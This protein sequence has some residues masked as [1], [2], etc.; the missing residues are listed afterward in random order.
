MKKSRLLSALLLCMALCHAGLRARAQGADFDPQPRLRTVLT[1]NVRN[2]FTDEGRMD[3]DDVAATIRHSGADLVALQELDSVTGRSGGRYVLGE[4]ATRTDMHPAYAP[5]IGYDGGKYG[6]GILSRQQPL[7]VRRVALPGR[8]EAR[9]ML[10][11]EFRDFVFA[12]THLSLTEQDRL[13]SLP[14][15]RAEAARYGKPF[16]L[17]GDFNDTPGS[18]FIQALDSIFSMQPSGTAPT[19]PATDPQEHIDYI[20]AYN[21]TGHALLWQKPS[22]PGH[23]KAS[24]HRPLLNRF[25]LRTPLERMFFSDPYLQ[26]P[27]PDG[28]TVMFQTRTLVHSWVEYGT[29]TLRLHREQELFGGQAVCHDIEHRVRLTDLQPGTRYYYRV[30]A[31]ELFHYGSYSKVI[32]DTLHTRFYSFTTTS[33]RGTDFTALIFNDMHQVERTMETMARLAATVP[34]DF[35]IFNG[36]CLAEPANR[37]DAIR[38][39]RQLTSRFRSAEIPAFFVRGNHE[40]RNAYSAGMPSLQEQPGGQTYGAFSW[41]DT[42]F[43]VLDC[44]EDKP[45]DHWVYYGMNDFTKFREQQ[46]DFLRREMGGRDFKKAKR[47]VLVHHIPIWGNTDEYQPC[48]DMWAPLLGKGD[49][50]VDLGAHTHEF[51]Y[52]APGT[53][54]GNPFPVFVGGGPS[55]KAATMMILSKRGNDMTLRVLSGEG[56]ELGTWEL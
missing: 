36:D 28:M 4:L 30:C 37:L 14:L 32:G 40:I 34:H 23:G 55:V 1:Y 9:T 3:L 50:D 43:V 24:D 51:R 25:Y 13:A 10:M 42:R 46:C 44:G 5:A 33:D 54:T 7:S 17:A 31:R 21:P 49:F 48:H 26:N 15:L 45:D 6:I 12:C 41:G 52:H 19:Y 38:M 53:A 47:R 56:R 2:A 16:I 18:P 39:I 20:T 22:V 11:A 27:A 35:V 29:D 8:E